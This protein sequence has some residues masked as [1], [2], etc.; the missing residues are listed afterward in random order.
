MSQL[1]SVV[2]ENNCWRL[3]PFGG[4]MTLEDQRGDFTQPPMTAIEMPPAGDLGKS[5]KSIVEEMFRNPTQLPK[6]PRS[7][8]FT[9]RGHD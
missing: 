2:P 5:L 8:S 3:T 7:N 1:A 4:S 6:G 9:I